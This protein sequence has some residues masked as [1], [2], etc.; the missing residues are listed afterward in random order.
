MA[1]AQ[2]TEKVQE[3]A[4]KMRQQHVGAIVITGDGGRPTGILTDR[5]IVC[6][7]IAERRDPA[8]TAVREV[9]TRDPLVARVDQLIEQAALIMRQEG[10]RRLPIVDAEGRLVGLLA[11]DDLLVMLSAELSQTAAVVRV[12]KGP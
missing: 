8:A 10:V 11:L 4:E 2:L 12:N 5:D 7:V 1:T 9:M 6:R 3:V